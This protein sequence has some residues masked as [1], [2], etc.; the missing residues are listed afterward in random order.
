M[1]KAAA[2]RRRRVKYGRWN[3]PHL[4]ISWTV[5]PQ[6]AT[7]TIETED[8]DRAYPVE[9]TTT[10]CELP[11][12]SVV[13]VPQAGD[14]S[15]IDWIPKNLSSTGYEAVRI[16]YDFDVLAL[17][18]LTS[19]HVGRATAEPL[20]DRPPR[21]SEIL[22]CKKWSYFDF[23][24]PRYGETQCL[25]EAICCVAARV[26]QWVTSYG[27][28]DPMCLG[29]YTRAVKSLQAA[30]DDPLQRL[31]PNVLA[32]TQVL[33]IFE[34]LDDEQG[35]AWH[36]HAEGAATL[37]QL[38]GPE[39]Y[40][41]DFEKALFIS[42]VGPIYTESILKTA[43]CFLQQPEWQAVFQPMMADYS[44][45]SSCGAVIVSMW[46]S[47]GDIPSL[48][49]SVRNLVSSPSISSAAQSR[50]LARLM[51]L[52]SHLMNWGN[53]NNYSTTR[54]IGQQDF[55]Y[56]LPH[57]PASDVEYEV[58]GLYAA[59]LMIL[60]R[61]I[62]TL[63][64]GRTRIMEAHVQQ[65]AIEILALKRQAYLN[66]PRAALSLALKVMTAKAVLLTAEDWE[67][68]MSQDA[69]RSTIS[70]KVFEQWVTWCCPRTVAREF[71]EKYPYVSKSLW[72][73]MAET[74]PE[75]TFGVPHRNIEDFDRMIAQSREVNLESLASHS[76]FFGMIFCQNDN[77]AASEAS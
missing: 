33:A 74:G 68:E 76:C 75:K 6:P 32:A 61:L 51:K 73:W 48:F 25:D 72:P 19:I 71:R 5:V 52:R 37:T 10:A 53:E 57:L 43:H 35:H 27:V 77:M 29:L 70:N 60:E 4:P 15:R 17:S 14:V 8:Q 59:S 7:G 31:H 44:N 26:R 21:L 20:H 24:P 67:H 42:Q 63:D 11:Q 47:I 56:L 41:T 12:L 40:G 62:V 9:T 54:C 50:T 13:T 1:V 46:S 39:A 18:A 65:L 38:R 30:L 45:V 55:N 66:K 69:L 3:V 23:L 34:L 16:R 28:P 64:P 2:A 36:L 49:H 22:R 58:R